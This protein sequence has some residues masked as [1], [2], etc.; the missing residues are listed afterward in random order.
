MTN[1][2]DPFG[3][4]S[5]RDLNLSTH[6]APASVWDRRGWDGSADTPPLSRLL[7]GVGGGALAIQGLRR[8]G[9]TGSMLAGLGG[10]LAWWAVTGRSTFPD[11]QRWVCDARE[12]LLGQTDRVHEASADSFP[13]SDAP[14]WTPTVGAAPRR[15]ASGR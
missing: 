1:I 12:F 2:K 13:A 11:V 7:L 5:T 3:D 9:F 8:R 6:R 4:P 10:S 15:D 14:S